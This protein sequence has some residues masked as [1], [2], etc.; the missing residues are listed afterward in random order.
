[1]AR[2]GDHA[3]GTPSGIYYSTFHFF[4]DSPVLNNA[5]ETAFRA[6]LIGSGVDA[7]NDE[8]IWSEGSGTLALVAREGDH[9]P[10]TPIGVLYGTPSGQV[11][12]NAGHTAFRASLTGS[13]V[14]ISSDAG[15]WLDDSG[16]QMLVAREGDHA[17]GSPDGVTFTGFSSHVLNDAGQIAFMARTIPGG[18]FFDGIWATD[19]TGALQLI[20]RTGDS[21]EVAPG[22]F[23]TILG[24]TRPFQND[25]TLNSTTGN[26]DGR[27][28]GFNNVG[29]L[30]FLATFTDGSSGI[31]VSNRVAVP[32]PST[33]L[34]LCFGSLA[35]LWRRR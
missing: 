20:A 28:S 10:G 17:P 5:G 16:S 2:E 18:L 25:P 11:L 21:L 1:V 33:L 32:E 3:P 14:D 12:N 7:T 9:A 30:A 31:F 19:R 24:F 34:L 13:G 6:A 27:R 23:R 4:S 26:S 35:V 15:I 29:Q 22:D 8:G